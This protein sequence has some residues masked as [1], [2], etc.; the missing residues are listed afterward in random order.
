MLHQFA[1]GAAGAG[2]Y[3]VGFGQ[4]VRGGEEGLL[5]HPRHLVDGLKGSVAEAAL[6]LVEDALEG[7]IVVGLGDN[8]QIGE[9]IPDFLA[10]V[11]ARAT[12]H[13]IGDAEL[14]ETLF[15]RAHLEG[16]A[17]EDGDVAELAAV[18]GD[19]LDVACD[20][21]GFFLCVPDAADGDAFTVGEVGPERLAEAALVRGYQ[22]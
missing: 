17:H 14:H 18:A 8:A 2:W 13:A 4:G 5:Q 1:D 12:D 11:E 22:A 10:L 7:E 6:G 16:G 20:G 15:K 3:L 19:L 9:G 21:A